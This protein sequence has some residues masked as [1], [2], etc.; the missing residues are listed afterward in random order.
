MRRLPPLVAGLRQ[1]A[2]PRADGSAA[3]LAE[4]LLSGVGS[5][6]AARLAAVLAADPPL[7]LWTVCVADR[8]EAY[9][10]QSVAD[11]AH[12]LARH[13]PEVLQWKPGQD[14]GVAT[15]EASPAETFAERVAVDVQV[16]DL[17]GQLVAS[18]GQPAVEKATYLGLLHDA[19]AWLAAVG[20]SAADDAPPCLPNWL[21]QVS[22]Q[23][24]AD[25]QS[26][27]QRR[28]DSQSAL[29]AAA[30]ADL[31]AQVLSGVAPLPAGAAVDLEACRRRAAEVR[32]R[33]IAPAAGLA[34]WL[35]E[36]AAKLARLAELETRFQHAVE[37]E[38]LEALA[39]F[40]AGAG[41][42]I[43]NPLTVI[44]GRAQ[45]FLREETDPE[46]R[47]A[48]A[49]MNAQAM[50]VYEMIADMRLFA[51][52]PQPEFEQI[53]LVGLIDR[54]IEDFTPRAAQQETSICRRGD[55]GPM[56]IA[57]DPTQLS[58]A[59]RAMCQNALEAIGSGGHIEIAVKQYAR[60][61]QISVCDDGPGISAEERRHL[62]DPF[63]SARQ[64]GRGLGLGLSKCWR[65]VTNHGGRID[66]ESQPGH[67]A[68][69]TI[70]LPRR[71]S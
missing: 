47:H 45:L 29:D 44:A 52:P 38:K 55:A 23:R 36:L 14:E 37:Q 13:A 9:Q 57:A 61:V 34:D 19:R 17:A 26:A 12:W 50:R 46:R 28:T 21:A 53:E 27:D 30:A 65:I 70:T 49:L 71:Q 51:R 63:Y 5:G 18:Q 32:G 56:E 39:E 66:V 60:E 67:G 64:A 6:R 40:A 62:F 25:F 35:P 20:G 31:A 41:H 69:F 10:P 8:Q 24:R 54:L 43:N 4:V 3:A 22:G 7:L 58:V 48:L 11:A 68:T 33:W 16:A 2:L 15:A 42:E 59:I 1:W